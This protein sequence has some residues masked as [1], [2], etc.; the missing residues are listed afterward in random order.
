MLARVKAFPAVRYSHGT[1]LVIE[2]ARNNKR[3]KKLTIL[4]KKMKKAIA[5]LTLAIML[6]I[7]AGF[8]N[9]QDSSEPTGGIIIAGF[10]PGIIIAGYYFSPGIII[11]G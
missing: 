2:R 9:A 10:N 6:T 3:N 7:G 11:A 4:E 1:L 8:A 5:T